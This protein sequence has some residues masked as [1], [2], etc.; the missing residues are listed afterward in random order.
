MEDLPDG[1]LALDEHRCILYAN[2]VARNSHPS[3]GTFIS[4]AGAST[5]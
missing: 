4:L 1:I 2:G 5:A 3:D